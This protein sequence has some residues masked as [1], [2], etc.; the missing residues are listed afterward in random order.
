[1]TEGNRPSAVALRPYQH[2]VI[3]DLRRQLLAGVTRVMLVAPTG[4]GKTVIFAAVIKEVADEG[5]NVLVLAHRRE[6]VGQTR[7]KLHDNEIQH[8][9]IQAGTSGRPLERVQ[10]ASIQTLHRRA[11][12]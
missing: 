1:V 3:A 5:L 6:I 2:N 10:V 4:S 12:Q 8:G 7:N 11:V 9:V